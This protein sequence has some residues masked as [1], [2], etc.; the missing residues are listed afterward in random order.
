MPSDD[1]QNNFKRFEILTSPVKS[2]KIKKT[3]TQEERYNLADSIAKRICSHTANFGGEE[4]HH[5]INALKDFEDLIRMGKRVAVVGIN[6]EGQ[7]ES[8][9]K[10]PSK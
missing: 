5:R 8:Q 9:E 1:A 10:N 2:A 3:M 4:F 7:P 6:G